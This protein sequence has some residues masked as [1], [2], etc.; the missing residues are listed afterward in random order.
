[1][2]DS[3]TTTSTQGFFSRLLG[4][5]VGILLGPVLVIAAIILLFVE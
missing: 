4:S 3:F 1:M 2:P 5:F